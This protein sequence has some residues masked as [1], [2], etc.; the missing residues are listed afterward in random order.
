ML[1]IPGLIMEPD[2]P[3]VGQPPMVFVAQVASAN[4]LTWMGQVFEFFLSQE[5]PEAIAAGDRVEAI[6][7]PEMGQVFVIGKIA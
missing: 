2:L 4:S 7:V 5:C 3:G 1:P 6:Y